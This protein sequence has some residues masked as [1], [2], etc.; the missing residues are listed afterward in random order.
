MD[1]F[2]EL[3]DGVP[4]MCA[5]LP[6]PLEVIQFLVAEIPAGRQGSQLLIREWS[7]IS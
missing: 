4:A 5:G 2:A 7:L 6:M 1:E 3:S